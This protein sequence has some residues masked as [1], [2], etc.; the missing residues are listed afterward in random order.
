MLQRNLLYTGVTR[1]RNVVILIGDE[2]T[3]K[4][5][6]QN[7][8]SNDRRTLLKKRLLNKFQYK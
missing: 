2:K 7:N 3:L 6:V 5:A 4:Y 8:I 1:A